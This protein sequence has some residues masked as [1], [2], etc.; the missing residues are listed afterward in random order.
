M[1]R[2]TMEYQT[3]RVNLVESNLLVQDLSDME[4][5]EYWEERLN[6]LKQPFAVMYQKTPEGKIVYAI[7]TEMGRKGNA[8]R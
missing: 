6:S 7:Y 4:T 5:L 2:Y 1:L 8:F 3:G